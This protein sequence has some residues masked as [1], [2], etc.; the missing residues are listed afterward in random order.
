MNNNI[1]N[2]VMDSKE[3]IA[4]VKNIKGSA[5]KT[6]RVA[7]LLKGL[8]PDVAVSTLSFLN[9]RNADVLKKVIKTAINN[10][11]KK[12]LGKP[13]MIKEIRID[14]G[15]TLKRYRYLSKGSVAMIHKRTCNILV[16][17]RGN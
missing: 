7:R 16:K 2:K 13:Y 8:S 4:S 12:N 11:D 6:R 9:Y 14:E 5:G 15:Q 1:E 3:V 10:A 17:L